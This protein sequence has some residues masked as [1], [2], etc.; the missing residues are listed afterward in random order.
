MK[1]LVVRAGHSS[2]RAQLI[3]QHS[4]HEYQ[5]KLAGAI[6]IDVR[7][8]RAEAEADAAE[9]AADEGAT[10]AVHPFVPRACDTGALSGKRCRSMKCVSMRDDL[11]K[12][13][14][15]GACGAQFGAVIGPLWHANGTRAR[16]GLDN[17]QGPG[18]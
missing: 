2:E 18:L 12:C 13:L 5:R 7:R 1:D 14:P 4:T 16:I 9:R 15:G 17:E 10:P 11:A 8:R 6:D 3:Y